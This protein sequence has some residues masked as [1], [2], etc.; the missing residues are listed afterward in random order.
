MKKSISIL[1][2]ALSGLLLCSFV[3]EKTASKKVYSLGTNNTHVFEIYSDSTFRYQYVIDTFID[4]VSE[5]TWTVRKNKDLIL[6]S[7]NPEPLIPLEIERAP[8]PN[9]RQARHL[10]INLISDKGNEDD[11][12]VIPQTNRVTLPLYNKQRGSQVIETVFLIDNISFVIE[13]KP[14][15]NTRPKPKVYHH[16]ISL[17]PVYTN[18]ET[19]QVSLRLNPGESAHITI[20]IKDEDFKHRTFRNTR[21][22]I[23]GKDLSF[24]DT[25]VNKLVKLK[26]QEG[27]NK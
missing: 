22:Q 12:F 7:Y 23:K 16:K 14:K 3:T 10:H 1:L 17:P 15:E 21:V 9:S 19:E 13:K 25:D 27:K 8:T 24:I 4:V 5:G 26:L 11:F 18:K 20:R 2:L 6:N